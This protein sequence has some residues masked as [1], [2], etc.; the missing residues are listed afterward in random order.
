[1]TVNPGFGGQK[2]LPEM[3]PKIRTHRPIRGRRD[4]PV[5]KDFC[6]RDLTTVA[7]DP[8]KL[9]ALSNMPFYFPTCTSASRPAS[10][11]RR[12]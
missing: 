1:M 12:S 2:L 3:L 6:A 7:V 4:P 5:C 10:S 11:R 8:T 9:F